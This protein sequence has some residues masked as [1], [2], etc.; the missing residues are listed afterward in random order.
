[1]SIL[2]VGRLSIVME[3]SN[4]SIRK[5]GIVYLFSQT[6]YF[7]QE[8]TRVLL[9]LT[10]LRFNLLLLCYFQIVSNAMFPKNYE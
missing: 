7:F 10:V 6:F 8:W 4:Q 1:M 5:V 3:S 2:F 9:P